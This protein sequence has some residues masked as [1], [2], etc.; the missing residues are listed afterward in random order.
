M[1]RF[2]LIAMVLLMLPGCGLHPLYAGGSHGAVAQ[3]LA[4]I[5]VAPIRGQ[6][7]WLL[8]NALVDRLGEGG[9][10]ATR[11]RL[12][13]ELDDQTIGLGVRTDNTVTRERRTLRA[14]YK[15]VDAEKGTILLDATAGSDVGLDV[16]SSD[17]ANVAA[18]QTA[19]ENLVSVVSDQIVARLGL[20]ASRSAPR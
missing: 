14:R 3:A 6:A 1:K 19:L 16:V 20:Y 5:E 13:I 10:P 17:Y 8:R 12:E 7:G 4:G 15:L 2:A 18:E 11:Y 9:T